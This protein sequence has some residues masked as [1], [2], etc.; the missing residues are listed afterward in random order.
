MVAGT[1]EIQMLANVARLA[2]DMAKA[3]RIVSGAVETMKKALATIGVGFTAHV[4]IE[5]INSVIEGM[6]KLGDE[7]NKT[8]ASVENLSRLQFFAQASSTNIESVNAALVKLS[9][10]MSQANIES[11]AA[12]QAFSFLG[13]SAKDASG[14]LKDPAELFGEIAHKLIEYQDGAGKAAIAQALFG[15]AGAA[16]LPVLKKMAELGQV[17]AIVTKEQAMRAEEYGV[18]LILLKRQGEALWNT[19]VGEMLPSMR[20]FV[21]LLIK[22]GQ[23]T[24]SVGSAVKGFANDKSIERWSDA[25]VMGIA[26][27]IDVLKTLP[28]LIKAVGGSFETVWEDVRVAGKFTVMSNPLTSAAMRLS[29]RDPEKEFQDALDRRNKVLAAANKNYADLWNMPGNSMEQAAARAIALRRANAEDA[30]RDMEGRGAGAGKGKPLN[31]QLADTKAMHAAQLA[32]AEYLKARTKNELDELKDAAQAKQQLLDLAYQQNKVSDQQYFTEKVAIAK[33]ATDAEIR[34]VDELR[35]AQ[36]EALNRVKFDTKEYWKILKDVEETEAKRAKLVKGFGDFTAEQWEKAKI[37]ALAYKDAVAGIDAQ[38]LEMT[39]HLQAAAAIRFDISNRNLLE[40]AFA[41]GDMDT[42]EKI[43]TLRKLTLEQSQYNEKRVELDTLNATL[44]IQ[45]AAVS[46]AMRKGRVSEMDGLAEIGVLRRQAIAEQAQ[47]VAG[48]KQI[49]AESQ[50][51]ALKLWAMQAEAALEKLRMEADPLGDKFHD[52]FV[53]GMA[54]ALNDFISGTKSAGEA[55]KSFTNSVISSLNRMASEALANQFWELLTGQKRGGMAGGTPP[56]IGGGGGG[57]ILGM[58]FGGGGFGGVSNTVPGTGFLGS[59]IGGTTFADALAAGVIPMAGG[60]DFM[61]NR[62][63]LFLAGEAGRERA[64]FSDPGERRDGGRAP[65]VI[66][67][68]HFPRGTDKR[69]SS[70]AAVAA[71][72]AVRR[73]MARDT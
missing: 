38:I 11:K 22:L 41:A 17:E 7:S 23:E 69:S 42:V 56:F 6:A 24:D 3:N 55:F 21:E 63:T 9:K 52:I 61:V 62:P 68:Q 59:S 36:Y 66:I 28:S 44:Q 4:L 51:P 65:T 8:G 5:K 20:T 27:L 32:F 49:A 39:G 48:L 58:L 25:A 16:M 10:G 72:E 31:F 2:E 53:E 47:V 33:S 18:Q 71:G 57:G 73:Q 43:G 35:D 67:H 70:Q 64:T 13:L 34:A 26:R 14:N 50:N 19:V 54:P 15:N 45:E 46:D 12:A 37:A 40:K 29:G 60:G 30:A 1:L